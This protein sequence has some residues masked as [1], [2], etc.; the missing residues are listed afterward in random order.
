MTDRPARHDT[1]LSTAFLWAERSTCARLK[2]GCVIS[3]EGRIL[4][5]GYNGAPAGMPHCDYPH[6]PEQC[7][8]VHAEANA[9]AFA[10]RWGVMLE[11]S[12]LTCTDEP[13]IN[14]ARLIINAGIV[15]VQYSRA[16]RLHDGLKLLRDAGIET[17]HF[18][19]PHDKVK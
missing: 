18:I 17:S 19:N 1:L 10:A 3:R 5:Q 9:I 13:C 8:A 6:E 14:C 16:Y 2:V 4:V 7:L 12:M 11:G 15:V